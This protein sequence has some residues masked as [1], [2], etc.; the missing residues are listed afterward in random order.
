[1]GI[2][3]HWMLKK[4]HLAIVL[5]KFFDQQ[6]LMHIFSR[7]AIGCRQE[8][9]VE[10]TRSC[11][12]TQAVQARTVQGAA[13]ETIIAKDVFFKKLPTLSINV[14]TE[15]FK[16]LFDRLGLSL[17][18]GRYPY[19]NCSS[20]DSPPE[21][22]PGLLMECLVSLAHWFPIAE[23]IGT[24]DPSVAVRPDKP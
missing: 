16:L 2:L 18:I 11:T 12:V 14:D 4:F 21:V 10:F 3:A 6:D 20:H 1:M 19:V 9:E 24:R 13:T 15:L 22:S 23:D 7:Q 8:N 17:M 5:L